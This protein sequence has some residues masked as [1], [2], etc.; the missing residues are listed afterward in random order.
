MAPKTLFMSNTKI[1]LTKK[2]QI[3]PTEMF[4]AIKSYNNY[5]ERW[6]ILTS[7]HTIHNGY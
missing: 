7:F 3:V 5:L 1:D 6:E 2:C 4:K